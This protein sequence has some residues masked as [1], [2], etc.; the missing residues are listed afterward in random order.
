[1]CFLIAC[2]TWILSFDSLGGEHVAPLKRLHN[3]LMFEAKDKRGLELDSSAPVISTDVPV[4]AFHPFL[5]L[6]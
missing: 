6:V 4:N 5:D 3:Y 2:R 1:M